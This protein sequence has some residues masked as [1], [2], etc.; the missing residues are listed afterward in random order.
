MA[1][2]GQQQEGANIVNIQGSI[3]NE[4]HGEVIQV[5][6][7]QHFH[8]YDIHVAPPPFAQ[9]PQVQADAGSAGN[10]QE[11]MPSTSGSASRL[12][13]RERRNVDLEYSNQDLLVEGSASLLQTEEPTNVEIKDSNIN[14][15]G[16]EGM[17]TKGEG[18]T[19]IIRDSFINIGERSRDGTT[20]AQ[21]KNEF[22]DARLASNELPCPVYEVTPPPSG[23]HARKFINYFNN[24]TLEQTRV[25][26]T[27][28]YK[29]AKLIEPDFEVNPQIRKVPDFYR[30]EMAPK[31]TEYKI[32]TEFTVKKSDIGEPIS[33]D[34]LVGHLSNKEYRYIAILGQAG[35][36]KSTIM[37]RL[38]R[39]LLVA[40]KLVKQ[41]QISEGLRIRLFGNT[42][43]PFK[44]IHHLNIKD[45]PFLRGNKAEE[46][47]SPCELLFGKIAFG[48]ATQDVGEGYEWLQENQ[49]M[50]ILFLD[51]LDQA[52]WNLLGKYNKMKYTDKSSTATIMW[53]L[54]TGNLFPRLT[55][56]I[57]SREHRIAFLP[58]E[59]R[60]QF[61]TALA[62]FTR[63]D[64]KRLF[65][66]VVG[67]DGEKVWKKLTRQ[68][69]ALIPLSSV[70]LFLIFNAIVCKFNPEKLPGTMTEVMLRIL[71]I[72]MRSDHTHERKRIEEILPNL[73][74]MS[75][76]GTKKKRVI[77][78][79]K[80]LTKFQ[81]QSDEV[82]DII[83]KVPGKNMFNQHL[84]EGDHLMFFSHQVLQ[85]VLSALYISNMDSTTFR[86]FIE[87]EFRD[88]HWAVVRHLL[89]GII[90]NPDIESNL[91]TNFSPDARQDEKKKI[92]REFLVS[93]PHEGMESYQKLE[94]YGTLYEA[95]DTDLIQSCIREIYFELESLTTA[96]MH[97]MSSNIRRCNHLTRV[98]LINCNLNAELVHILKSNLEGSCLK[99][100]RFDVSRN[101]LN[102]QSCAIL[103]SSLQKCSVE[104]LV[105]QNCNLTEKKIEALSGF[106]TLKIFDIGHNDLSKVSMKSLKNFI[107]E[108]NVE[109]LITDTEHLPQ[110]YFDDLKRTTKVVDTDGIRKMNLNTLPG[111]EKEK[112]TKL[113]QSCSSKSERMKIFT[114]MHAVGVALSDTI[115]SCV[116]AIDMSNITLTYDDLPTLGF[117]INHSTTLS[118]V[119]L[120]NCQLPPDSIAQLG[121][122]IKS[123]V[124]IN[125]LNIEKNYNLNLEDFIAGVKLC[126]REGRECNFICDVAQ[127]TKKDKKDFKAV[128]SKYTET[129][130]PQSAKSRRVLAM[131]SRL[132]MPQVP[133]R[134]Y[135][136]HTGKSYSIGQQRKADKLKKEPSERSS[137]Q[138][139]KIDQ[140]NTEQRVGVE[141]ENTK[142]LEKETLEKSSPSK[143]HQKT[144]EPRVSVET[145]NTDK[146]EEPLERSSNATNSTNE[147]STQSRT[148]KKVAKYKP[149]T[150]AE[151]VK[152]R[153]MQR[154]QSILETLEETSE[155]TFHSKLKKRVKIAALASD[156]TRFQV[157]A[158]KTTKSAGLR[159][160]MKD[161]HST[162]LS[163]MRSTNKDSGIKS[164][165]HFG[166]AVSIKSIQREFSG[167]KMKADRSKRSEHSIQDNVDTDSAHGSF[168]SSENLDVLKEINDHNPKRVWWEQS[169]EMTCKYGLG[170]VEN[171][172]EKIKRWLNNLESCKT[173][174]TIEDEDI[175]KLSGHGHMDLFEMKLDNALRKPEVVYATIGEE[176]GEVR[177]SSFKI[178]FPPGAV[179]EEKEFFFKSCSIPDE[180]PPKDF[181]LITP[182]LTCGLINKSNRVAGVTILPI[183]FA[184]PVKIT[185]RT[186]CSPKGVDVP[187]TVTVFHAN[188]NDK[189]VRQVSSQQAILGRWG[190]I[191][192]DVK[193]FCIFWTLFSNKQLNN[194]KFSLNNNVS[195]ENTKKVTSFF[196]K[197]EKNITV[198][199]L[200]N[201]GSP[202]VTG[203]L[204]PEEMIISQ[205]STIQLS[206]KCKFPDGTE[207]E[208]MNRSF[209]VTEDWLL[210]R[211]HSEYFD[212]MKLALQP[213]NLKIDYTL[214]AIDQNNKSKTR[215]PLPIIVEWPIK[216]QNESS[217]T[218][219]IGVN[220]SAPDCTIIQKGAMYTT[221]ASVETK[222]TKTGL[223]DRQTNV[224]SNNLFLHFIIT[225]MIIIIMQLL[226]FIIFK[227][228]Q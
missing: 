194:V 192:I 169:F 1:D 125:E 61:I 68:S 7:I 28:N 175:T 217:S 115:A 85:E 227:H 70:P 183:T 13:S 39:I 93:Q 143:T 90:L 38:A 89:G 129:S 100:K 48:L 73:M 81:L 170:V 22:A 144:T 26:I 50:C 65:I 46:A 159:R 176:G 145:G 88:D 140:K 67:Y 225:I 57:S 71:H 185:M 103:G 121:N 6:N 182:V 151:S 9:Q 224:P 137:L 69:P 75:F 199:D 196:W 5:D 152:Y 112:Y 147:N 18:A 161:T 2:Q 219:V 198:K 23:N 8:H 162:I 165:S 218:E 11:E 127:L 58:L 207:I 20:T 24:R 33:L 12:Q 154:F 31:V 223:D 30:G 101:Q 118:M 173:E 116:T 3:I 139:P 202:V 149:K 74:G 123:N 53:N 98:C 62:G 43:R 141:T 177:I 172:T 104:E 47:I 79:T 21:R 41:V 10:M 44:F 72:F 228:I 131:E 171:K 208:P 27:E 87:T 84:M 138:S 45:I 197:D 215:G 66:A 94:L 195:F 216:Q 82:R 83:I 92:L 34:V 17:I 49:S 91:I 113:L 128:V 36:G 153:K 167:L 166:S 148:M 55:I 184:K 214:K 37:K 52:T 174:L 201:S 117:I 86:T 29:E 135:K 180:Q 163:T 178:Y 105:M 222:D 80:D 59:L 150:V 126:S 106:D 77:F 226:T 108:N 95:N 15:M 221:A 119:N 60:P 136:K 158:T 193:D 204:L 213:C 99:V 132:Q 211:H 32:E 111:P 164:F 63:D 54:I 35:S 157:L 56:V 109:T 189:G 142:K 122:S 212:L 78:T 97:V 186:F 107:L 51:G 40:N 191:E 124:V 156:R 155:T 102:E 190:V 220:V 146:Q 206:M 14:I 96:G 181:S 19:T 120:R 110:E 25:N 200:S 16:G 76:E 130:S 42:G 114:E 64:I 4:V 188:E 168:G 187:V 205:D 133:V 210:K 203:F 160:H 179:K 134:R 209:T